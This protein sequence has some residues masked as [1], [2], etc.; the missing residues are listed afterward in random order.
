MLSITFTGS[1]L[2]VIPKQKKNS[3]C[4]NLFVVAIVNDANCRSRSTKQNIAQII[5]NAMP[6]VSRYTALSW[7]SFIRNTRLSAWLL[8]VI[9]VSL[10]VRTAAYNYDFSLSAKDNAYNFNPF[11]KPLK[12]EP[13]KTKQPRALASITIHLAQTQNDIRK[14]APVIKTPLPET[15]SLL[16]A[17]DP[18]SQEISFR[19]SLFSSVAPPD[20]YILNAVF[21]I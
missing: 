18:V 1:F 15:A 9:I 6:V 8:G 16:A 7:Q 4:L 2:V 19:R 20:I 13:L 12:K 5:L 21:R 10:A 17:T 3:I 14:D 11:Y